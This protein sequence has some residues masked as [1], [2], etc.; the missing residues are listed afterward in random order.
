[1]RQKGPSELF[2]KQM[3][4]DQLIQNGMKP[5]HAYK[6]AEEILSKGLLE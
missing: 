3:I 2:K 4:V 5:K 6:Q 1:M